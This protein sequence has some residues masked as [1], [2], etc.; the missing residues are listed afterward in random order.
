MIL[1]LNKKDI[2]RKKLTHIP[3]RVDDGPNKR[4][5]DYNGPQAQPGTPSAQDGTKEFEQ[6]YDSVCDYLID[7]YK[8]AG[9]ST[10]NSKR[11]IY[12]KVTSATDSDQVKVVMSSC[13]DIILK[14]N[15]SSNGFI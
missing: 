10:G 7:K 12:T 2:L 11:E 13:K 9:R 8:S 5:T 15:L 14:S 6:V 3:F 1:F 4:N